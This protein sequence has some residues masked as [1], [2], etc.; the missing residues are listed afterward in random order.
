MSRVLQSHYLLIVGWLRNKRAY[1]VAEVV[2]WDKE[3]RAL[4]D[5]DARDA[6]LMEKAQYAKTARAV[7]ICIVILILKSHAINSTLHRVAHGAMHGSWTVL[8]K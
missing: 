5:Q 8:M 2:R 1:F 3:Y 6:W 7:S 4:G